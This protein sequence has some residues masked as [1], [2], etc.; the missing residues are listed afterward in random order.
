VAEE[1]TVRLELL[2]HLA[3]QAQAVLVET[4]EQ[5]CLSQPK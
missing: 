5:L 2:E 4:V 1:L 3:Q